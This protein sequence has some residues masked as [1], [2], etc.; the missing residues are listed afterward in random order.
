[1]KATELLRILRRRANKLSVQHEEIEAAG[2]H[3]K[4][5][6]DGHTTIIPMHRTDLPPG[7]LRGILKH[8]TLTK[9]DLEF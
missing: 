6:H 1:M 9:Q 2:S 7:T 4:I 5:R 8:L 3:L